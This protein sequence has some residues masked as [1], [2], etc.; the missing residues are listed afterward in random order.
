MTRERLEM[1]TSGTSKDLY[2]NVSGD[3]K[4]LWGKAKA[5][6]GKIENIVKIVK[7]IKK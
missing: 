4:T 5:A 6:P 7:K 1:Y 2:K 3:A